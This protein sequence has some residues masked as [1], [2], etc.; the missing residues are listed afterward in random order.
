MKF[1]IAVLLLAAG[2]ALAAD[3]PLIPY[4]QSVETSAGELAVTAPVTIT[5]L[6]KTYGDRFT[7]TLLQEEFY[8]TTGVRATV[9]TVARPGPGVLIGYADDAAI[10]KQIEKRGL[11]PEVLSKAESYLLSIDES[12]ALIASKTPAGLFYGVQ[13]LRQ[14]IRPAATRGH[15]T[16]PHVK[17]ADWPALRYRALS[18]DVSRGP[19]LNEEQMFTAIRTLAEYKLNMV[20]FYMEHVFPYKHSPGVA[21]EGAELSP[22]LIKRLV[23]YAR[24]FH[25]EIVPQQQT[26]G[27]LH[28]MLKMELYSSMAE[29]PYGHVL[30]AEDDKAFQW[31]E[32]AAKQLA[33]VF[34]GTF[35]HIGS[36]ETW[37]L[38]RGRSKDY[39]A[40][41]GI[42]NVYMERIRR[43]IEML[44]PLK[45]RPMFWGDIA[46]NHPELIP[47][48]PKELVAMTWGYSPLADFS[49]QILPFRD[50]G[51]DFFVCPGVSNWNRMFP[52]FDDA[53]GNINNFVRDGKKYGALGMFNT[54]WRDDGET[55]LNMAWHPVVFSAAAAWQPGTVDVAKFD[56]AFD[57]AFY[58]NA[59][60]EFVDSIHNLARIHALVRST[61]IGD[62]TDS[63]FWFDP[64]SRHG[65]DWVRRLLPVAGEARTLA[66]RIAIQ[67]AACSAKARL[68]PRSV[69]YLRFAALRAD[70]TF[71]RVE[72]A[73]EISRLYREAMDNPARTASLL[74]S[75]SSPN[76][77]VQDIR[78]AVVQRKAEYRRLWL[79]ENRPYFLDSMLARYDH[80]ILYW[81]AKERLFIQL[82]HD[83]NLT[84]SLPS[85][86]QIGLMLP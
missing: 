31:V 39:A 68:H 57:W 35:L 66:E 13:T 85:P 3:L 12:G 50:A 71:M 24:D 18:I 75:V 58:R 86:E 36:D 25:V 76:G 8:N 30:A 83:F 77:L 27:H 28:H 65:A 62:A 72:L 56:A 79:D 40:R 43:V 33:E 2:L 22:A 14:L 67:L 73:S 48:L 64:F 46:L 51:M 84:K 42:G 63:L 21:P 53:V 70:T 4:P 49:R 23:E 10:A 82:R 26:F 5:V 55:L 54:D 38:G 69:D 16:I 15:A 20:S 7:A 47:K 1:R 11:N 37:E 59:D 34:P 32:Q 74:V 45:R 60:G 80:E 52:N 61:K 44:S 6:S 81:T 29:L 17:I 9:S 78:D 19:I 41:V